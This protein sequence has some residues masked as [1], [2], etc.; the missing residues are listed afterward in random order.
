MKKTRKSSKTL[1]QS[2]LAVA[3]SQ[4]GYFTVKQAAEIGYDRRRFAYHVEAGNFERAAHGLYRLPSLPLSEHDELVRL[5]L[6][7]R[8][9][10]GTPLAVVS[11]ETAL[12]LHGLGELIPSKTHLTV[13]RTFRKRSMRGVV[14]HTGT[15]P[16][17]ERTWLDGFEITTPLRT[18]VDVS[19]GASVPQE[20]LDNAVQQA[21]R[22]GLV[23][24]G[25]LIDLIDTQRKLKRLRTSVREMERAAT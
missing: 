6:W 8:G 14:F 25:Q 22:K 16:K 1:R 15:V 2:L 18:L 23:G 20:Q 17:T 3:A 24:K 5:S 21:V 12:D 10:T 13:P 7:S 4:G 9:R 11:H 19:K